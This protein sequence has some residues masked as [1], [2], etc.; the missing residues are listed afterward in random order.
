VRQFGRD[1]E[2]QP[3]L[4]DRPCRAASQAGTR[5]QPRD[6]LR[7]RRNEVIFWQVAR[8]SLTGHRSPHLRHPVPCRRRS[9]PESRRLHRPRR[10][11]RLGHALITS[12]VTAPAATFRQ[13]FALGGQRDLTA[14]RQRHDATRWSA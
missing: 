11:D 1:L 10:V 6:E 2:R 7:S 3:G 8:I 4:R 9:V 12:A 14:P 5:Q 13:A